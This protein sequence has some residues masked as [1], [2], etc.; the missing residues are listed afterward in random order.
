M[1]YTP[2]KMRPCYKGYL[3]GGTRL[4]TEYGKWDAPEITAESWELSAHSDGMSTVENGPLAGKTLVDLAELNRMGYWGKACGEGAFPILI[5]LIDAKE[6]LSIQVH[7]SDETAD[8][9]LGETGK[10]ELWYILDC[11]PQSCIYLGF[12][13]KVTREQFLA[14]ARDGS[15]L[16]RLNRVPVSRGDVF[17]VLPGV[18]HAIGSGILI[19]EIQRNSNTT[20]RIYDYGRRGAD[21]AERPLHLERAAQTL[22]YAPLIPETC[23]ANNSVTF[24]E[25]CLSEMYSCPWFHSYCADVYRELDLRCDGLSFQHLLCTDGTGEIV[26]KDGRSAFQRG[27]S[28]F[29][30]AAMGFYKI[31]GK[32]RFLLTRL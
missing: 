10:T 20:F 16:E 6:N 9:S 19:A 17:Y 15:I 30:P 14:S 25:F 27:D 8:V 11:Q 13:Q 29:L 26:T 24:P 28:W 4:K 3:W 21:G 7:P 2:L 23:R 32:C 18:I 12:S 31:R 1:M 22:N 5:K